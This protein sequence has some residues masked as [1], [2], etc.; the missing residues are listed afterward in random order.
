M[1]PFPKSPPLGGPPE[2]WNMPAAV[3]RDLANGL[4]VMAVRVG[5]LP[6][7]QA[8]W[9]FAAGRNLER[10]DRIGSGFLLQRV[11]RHGT[12]QVGA[13]EFAASLDRL[14]ARMGGGVSIDASVV[15]I[16]GLAQHQGRIVDLVADVALR[17]NLSDLALAGEKVRS[18]ALHHHAC[19]RPDSIV[20]MMLDRSIY[21]NHPYGRPATTETGISATSRT[22]LVAMHAAI[23]HPSRGMLLVVGDIDPHEVVRRFSV[24]FADLAGG[25]RV[26]G[27]APAAPAT[28]P[29]R[30]LWV[31]HPTAEQ[32]T[33]GVGGLAVPRNHPEHAALRIAN[34]AVGGGS[35]SRLFRSLRSERALTYAVHSSLDCGVD[36]GDMTA[37]MATEPG[38][39][40]EGFSAMM[41]SLQ[42]VVD[43][44]MNAD[45]IR[46]AKRVVMG[47]FPQRAGGLTGVASLVTAGWLHALPDDEWSAFIPRMDAVS[48]GEVQA[49]C[50][51]WFDPRRLTAVACGPPASEAGMRA[52][53]ERYGLAFEPTTVDD[54][55]S[56][57][58]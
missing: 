17:P 35:G 29:R 9:I 52:A 15:S 24:R 33:I 16:A 20:E 39:A 53:A 55:A 31:E 26:V 21:G 46:H 8:R 50:R 45:E 25:D 12:Q 47:S 37:S 18:L 34:Q 19:A 56:F 28:A 7:V 1:N 22:D 27:D 44:P 30:L 49:A 51:R 10:R 54:L 13:R 43:R 2:P 4:R 42:Q 32:T 5:A 23:A 14:G 11:M 38:S 48:A 36:S 6:I 41:E 57:I 58:G 40:A 3:G